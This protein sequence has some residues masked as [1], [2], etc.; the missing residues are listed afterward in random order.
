M[1][2][3][4]PK[5]RHDFDGKFNLEQRS[6]KRGFALVRGYESLSEMTKLSKSCVDY[7]VFRQCVPFYSA[8]RMC[9]LE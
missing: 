2:F 7:A 5:N 3:K 6:S 9:E 4:W 1:E 8:M